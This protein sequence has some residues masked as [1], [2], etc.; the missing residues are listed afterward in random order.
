MMEVKGEKGDVGERGTKGFFGLKG[1]WSQQN[2]AST[3]RA[4]ERCL[5]SF[6]ILNIPCSSYHCAAAAP[7]KSLAAKAEVPATFQRATPE[8]SFVGLCRV[9]VLPFCTG[10]SWCHVSRRP[11][12]GKLLTN[13]QLRVS[14]PTFNSLS[15]L[16]F[17]SSLPAGSKGM[18]GVP[19]KTG[20]P[21]SPGHPSYVAGVKGD[22][23]AKGLTGLKGYPGPAGSPG[24]RGFPGS[25]GGRVSSCPGGSRGVLV[26]AFGFSRGRHS[27]L[28]IVLNRYSAKIKMQ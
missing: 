12:A 18:P 11:L 24:I 3:L 26:L 10:A 1:Q 16:Y 19:G 17:S 14:L 27:A 8:E 25:T 9:S 23:G 22:V 6:T 7:A 20:T 4:I 15:H 5:F 28:E 13:K 21:G 2:K